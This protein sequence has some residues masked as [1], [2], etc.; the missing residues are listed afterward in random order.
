MI[1]FLSQAKSICEDYEKEISLMR[2]KIKERETFKEL[3]ISESTEDTKHFISGSSTN[4]FISKLAEISKEASPDF[5][6]LNMVYSDKIQE[7]FLENDKLQ[8][9]IKQHNDQGDKIKQLEAKV[10]ELKFNIKDKESYIES[11]NGHI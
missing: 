6:M 10:E 5:N 2:K 11:M 9:I 3:Q 8:T 1:D 7:L 4:Y